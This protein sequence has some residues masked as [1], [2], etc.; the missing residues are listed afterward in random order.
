MAYAKWATAAPQDALSFARTAATKRFDK[1]SG[2]LTQVLSTWAGHDPQAALA[3]AQ[4]KLTVPLS[5]PSQPATVKVHLISGSITVTGGGAAGQ[6][7]VESGS[8]SPRRPPRDVPEGMHRIDIKDVYKRQT[9]RRT[10]ASSSSPSEFP[11]Q[12]RC[13]SVSRRRSPR[14]A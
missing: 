5:N 12:Q 14:R 4:D 6:I 9:L 1:D 2:P 3:A 7:A 10:P 11:S 8:R 13:C